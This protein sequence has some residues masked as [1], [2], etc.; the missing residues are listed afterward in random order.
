MEKVL[1]TVKRLVPA[2]IPTKPLQNKIGPQGLEP[3]T[4]GL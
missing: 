2:F 3:W 4:K 1:F